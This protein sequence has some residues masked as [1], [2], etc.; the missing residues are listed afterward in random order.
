MSVFI[1]SPGSA[2]ASVG[3][4][5]SVAALVALALLGCRFDEAGMP[6]SGNTDARGTRDALVG[7]GRLTPPDGAPP[8]GAV[9]CLDR[10]EDGFFVA[11]ADADCGELVDCDDFEPLAFPGQ[12]EFFTEARQSGGYDYN[13]DGVETP[14]LDTSAGG[15]CYWDW[16]SCE[17]T[18]WYGGVPAC[19][20]EG[21][22]HVCSADGIECRESD[23]NL[24]T[25]P[26]R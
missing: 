14:E 13:C 7:D 18:G 9:P 19:G 20:A 24:L 2:R 17:G 26:C 6:G 3:R 21:I 11:T 22:W 1:P 10:D 15:D 12:S 4:W 16:F 25:M 5:G 8:D 23:A